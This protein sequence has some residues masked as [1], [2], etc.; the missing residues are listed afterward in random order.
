MVQA[1]RCEI[2]LL[3]KKTF[4]NYHKNKKNR[5]LS[6]EMMWLENTL[7]REFVLSSR[8]A[9]ICADLLSVKKIRLYHDNAL[10]KE[11]GCGRTPWHYDDHHFPLETNDVIT[12]WIPAQYIPIEMGP[13]T[14]AKPLEVYKLVKDIKFNEYDTSYDRKIKKV[15]KN[16]HVS[17][18]E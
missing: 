9:K 6:L 12:A 2:L 1:L 7:I 3:L 15:F 8:I 13:L 14:F 16:N 4:R 5:F 17:I 18:V 11:S 10:V